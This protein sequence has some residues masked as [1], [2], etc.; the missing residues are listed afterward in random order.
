MW[1]DLQIT[2]WLLYQL[3]YVGS[4]S[5]ARAV[6]FYCTSAQNGHMERYQRGY[7]FEGGQRF[8][9]RYYLTVIVDGK[10]KRGQRSHRLCSPLFE[11]SRGGPRLKDRK[12]GKATR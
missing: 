5:Y 2:N 9:C 10:P 1:E 6:A 11:G 4:T 3:S 8:S 7:L 12:G